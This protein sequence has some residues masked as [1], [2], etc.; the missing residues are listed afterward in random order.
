MLVRMCLVASFA[1]FVLSPGTVS[2]QVPRD[3]SDLELEEEL[4]IER[5]RELYGDMTLTLSPEAHE[6]LLYR[7]IDAER[8]AAIALFVAGPVLMLG[9]A[10]LGVVVGS[11]DV[12][13]VA[14]PNWYPT[15]Q[16]DSTYPIL[17]LVMGGLGTALL[18]T[19][20]GLIV[21]HHARR[22][23]IE[24]QFHGSAS[25]DLLPGGGAVSFSGTF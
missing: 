17:G 6:E 1:V 15:V 20:I 16:Y 8:T 22:R 10:I 9:G 7:S 18:G 5:R 2:A 14:N 24:R 21:D 12:T 11:L 4:R 23:A 25:I 3:R 19:A 13:Y